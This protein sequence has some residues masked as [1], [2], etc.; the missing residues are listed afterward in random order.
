MKKIIRLTEQDLHRIVKE[1]I[2]RV[3]KET[4]VYPSYDS[5]TSYDVNQGVNNQTN[6]GQRGFRFANKLGDP[7]RVFT[8]N[9]K[10]T[11]GPRDMGSSLDE[12]V[13]SIFGEGR[14]SVEIEDYNGS[15]AVVFRLNG[16]TKVNNFEQLA[17]LDK[18]MAKK[19][20]F[21]ENSEYTDTQLI[22]IY[23]RE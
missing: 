7:N 3:L 21:L 13:R 18:I 19:R 6:G 20:C 15:H 16:V 2:K 1:S 22:L 23:V 4:S 17:E 11:T 12:I 10:M 14:G 5:T 9:K 8:P